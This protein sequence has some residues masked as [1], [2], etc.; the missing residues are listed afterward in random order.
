VLF[1]FQR[2]SRILFASAPCVALVAAA[3]AQTLSGTISGQVTDPQGNVIPGALVSVQNP[4][5]GFDHQT[6]SD[7]TGNFSFDKAL[8]QLPRRHHRSWFRFYY[9]RRESA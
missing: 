8:W 5:S 3:A 7:A 9:C 2:L 4:V 6:K 1:E